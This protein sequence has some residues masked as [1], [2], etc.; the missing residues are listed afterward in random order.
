MSTGQNGFWET[1][2][3]ALLFELLCKS[4]QKY[5]QNVVSPRWFVMFASSTL[6]HTVSV[7]TG[8]LKLSHS[9]CSDK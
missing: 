9:G 2:K 5:D 6:L 7:G 4:V 8:D 3:S 1:K